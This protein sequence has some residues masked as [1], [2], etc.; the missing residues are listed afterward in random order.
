ML[1]QLLCKPVSELGDA[2]FYF[3]T[4]KI[5]LRMRLYI[6]KFDHHKCLYFTVDEIQLIIDKP[7]KSV[8]D[9]A[10]VRV[11]E[12]PVKDSYF[13]VTTTMISA[14]RFRSKNSTYL[15]ILTNEIFASFIITMLLI[16]HTFICDIFYH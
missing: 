1:K 16:G 3:L 15:I 12:V 14:T 7:V 6:P 10:A 4:K 2:I 8:P 13:Q 9:N 11:P 5:Q